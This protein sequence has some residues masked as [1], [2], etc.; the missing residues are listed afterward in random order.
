MA[1]LRSIVGPW[2]RVLKGDLIPAPKTA[3]AGKVP[4]ADRIQA[5]PNPIR[6]HAST[7]DSL[8][9][10]LARLRQRLHENGNAALDRRYGHIFPGRLRRDQTLRSP[11]FETF[12]RPR[13][14]Y[15]M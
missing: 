5:F 12:P 8:T 13:S 2:L 14:I 1:A 4:K 7:T 15:G 10:A 6:G 3:G 9:V 11:H